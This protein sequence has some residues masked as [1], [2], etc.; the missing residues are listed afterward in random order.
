V[1]RLQPHPQRRLRQNQLQVHLLP[2]V[3]L[4]VP[5]PQH[6]AKSQKPLEERRAPKPTSTTQRRPPAVAVVGVEGERDA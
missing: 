6:S 3:Q 5:Y 4:V 1:P 2:L